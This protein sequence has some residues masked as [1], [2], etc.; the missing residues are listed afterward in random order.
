ME[1]ASQAI[2]FLMLQINRGNHRAIVL[3]STRAVNDA[4]ASLRDC[5]PFINSSKELPVLSAAF[6][7]QSRSFGSLLAAKTDLRVTFRVIASFLHR[8]CYT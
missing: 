3:T 5:Q 2:P 4:S 7:I 6:R 8:K 1:L